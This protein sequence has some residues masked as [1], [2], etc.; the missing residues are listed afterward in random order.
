MLRNITNFD[1]TELNKF[2]KIFVLVSGGIDSTIL[3]E[4]CLQYCDNEKVYAVNCYNPYETSDTLKEISKYPRFIPIKP[5]HELDYKEILRKAFLKVPDAIEA[6]KQKKYH[7]HIFPCCK[8]IKHDAFKKHPLFKG[9]NTVVISGIKPTD[10]TQRRLWLQYLRT[11]VPTT[12]GA[13][14]LS[15]VPTF[16]YRHIEGQLYCYPFRDYK[17]EKDIEY[18]KGT[19]FPKDVMEELRKKYHTLDHSG[20]A[21]CPVLIV[22]EKGLR[23]NKKT[24]EKDLFRLENSLK[25]YEKIKKGE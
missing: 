17:L 13:K 7:K 1:F 21:I 6:R 14:P 2:D 3:F 5:I 9:P 16:Y 22:F 12:K 8:Y 15:E 20:C 11:G 18:L 25:Y 10:G 19:D 24:S 23:K 4:Y